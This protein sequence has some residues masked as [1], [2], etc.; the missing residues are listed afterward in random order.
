LL[1]QTQHG[2]DARGVHS[3]ACGTVVLVIHAFVQAGEMEHCLQKILGLAKSQENWDDD[4]SY[5]NY[6]TL[7]AGHGE[8][9]FQFA[10][11]QEL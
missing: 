10:K 3:Q 1:V 6:S 7:N 2:D 4:G 5:L 9:G 8:E 11:T